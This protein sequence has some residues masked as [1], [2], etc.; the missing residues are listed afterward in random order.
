MRI[1]YVYRICILCNRYYYP[2]RCAYDII[3]II[4]KYNIITPRGCNFPSV[5]GENVSTGYLYFFSRRIQF[6]I[7]IYLYYYYTH[8]II[9]IS[10]ELQDVVFIADAV[11]TRCV[12]SSSSSLL[13]LLFAHRGACARDTTWCKVNSARQCRVAL[14]ETVTQLNTMQYNVTLF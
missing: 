14:V 3:I 4:I 6:I 12:L 5:T 11:Y 1:V 10:C 9:I 7:L 8:Y 13:L 2:A